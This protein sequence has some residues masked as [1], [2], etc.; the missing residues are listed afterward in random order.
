[1]FPVLLHEKIDGRIVAGFVL[2]LGAVL[3]SEI[4]IMLLSGFK[5][6]TA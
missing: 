2:I 6:D 4:K 1:L 5:R 3:V